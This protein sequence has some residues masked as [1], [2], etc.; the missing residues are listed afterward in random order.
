MDDILR[1]PWPFG[2]EIPRNLKNLMSPDCLGNLEIIFPDCLGNL[3]MKSPD[4]LGNLE[5]FPDCL[6][7][8]QIAFLGNLEM[9]SKIAQALWRYSQIA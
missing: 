7:N 3:E 4:R 6:G 1:F 9:K 5:I 2:D 8:L